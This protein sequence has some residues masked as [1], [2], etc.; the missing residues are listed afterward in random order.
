MLCRRCFSECRD[1]HLTQSKGKTAAA[2]KA[3]KAQKVENSLSA[4]L[5][6]FCGK[7]PY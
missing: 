4:Y 7:M 2:K 1:H 3:Q 5:V 6:L